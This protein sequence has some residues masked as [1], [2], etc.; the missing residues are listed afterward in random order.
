MQAGCRA[1]S[2]V[3]RCNVAATGA[4][5][6]V[7]FFAFYVRPSAIGAAIGFFANCDVGAVAR[8]AFHVAGKFDCIGAFGQHK[9]CFLL[10]VTFDVSGIDAVFDGAF[11]GATIFHNYVNATNIGAAPTVANVECNVVAGCNNFGAVFVDYRATVVARNVVGCCRA[12][13]DCGTIQSD[14]IERKVGVVLDESFC[15]SC[16]NGCDCAVLEGNCCALV[17]LESVCFG[18]NGTNCVLND[19]V[20]ETI[21]IEGYF[22]AACDNNAVATGVVKQFDC[23]FGAIGGQCCCRFGQSLMGCGCCANGELRCGRNVAATSAFAT[24]CIASVRDVFFAN[25]DV[26]LFARNCTGEVNFATEA[27]RKNQACF[28]RPSSA[29]DAACCAVF[30][31]ALNGAVAADGNANAAVVAFEHAVPNV[32]CNV[33]ARGKQLGFVCD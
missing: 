17:K 15:V 7:F 5:F 30:H 18:A 31:K 6:A 22:C 27:C 21:Q 9:G 25:C 2:A 19:R 24:L 11:N 16:R 8:E 12:L 13:N 33:F 23:C 29:C 10:P 28:C 20:G 3:F 4:G 14:A 1:A 32:Y 26:G